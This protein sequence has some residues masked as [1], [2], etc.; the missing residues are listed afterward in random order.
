MYKQIEQALEKMD[1][2]NEKTRE[3]MSA[4]LKRYAADEI[5]LDE[6]YYDLLEGEL[7]PMPQRCGM[8]AKIP[9]SAEDEIRLKE[10]IRSR[11]LYK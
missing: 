8:S 10:K 3:M 9:L 2:S 7:I 1:S 5:G 4:I 6:A 11:L